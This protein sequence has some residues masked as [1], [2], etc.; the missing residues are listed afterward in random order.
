MDQGKDLAGKTACTKH[1]DLCLITGTHIKYIHKHL[2]IQQQL[3]IKRDYG[4]ERQQREVYGR[5]GRDE[6]EM[7]NDDNIISKWKRNN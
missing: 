6:R 2:Y 3:M 4:F 5:V 1:D 7:G